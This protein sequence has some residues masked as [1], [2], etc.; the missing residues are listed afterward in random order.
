MAL[1]DHFFFFPFFFFFPPSPPAHVYPR[2]ARNSTGPCE[3]QQA[4]SIAATLNG[5]GT[6]W[7]FFSDVSFEPFPFPFFPLLPFFFPPPDFPLDDLD[8]PFPPLLPFFFPGYQ[9][10]INNQQTRCS[11][12]ITIT[13]RRDYYQETAAL[14]ISLIGQTLFWPARRNLRLCIRCHG[15]N[16]V[17]L[18]NYY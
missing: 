13:T 4:F 1:K 12:T 10:I 3:I 9:T 17:T 15:N 7:A 11:F 6:G 18:I 14:I 5:S 8:F 2:N 16:H